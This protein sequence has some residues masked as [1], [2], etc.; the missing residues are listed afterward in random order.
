MAG[1]TAQD[2]EMLKFYSAKGNRELYFNYLAQKEGNDGYGLLALGVVRN[3]NAPGATANIFA[4][5]QARDDGVRMSER[6]WQAFGVELMRNDFALR[7][8]QVDAGRPDLALN[9]PVKDVQ[10]SHDPTFRRREINPDAWTPRQLL[11][12]ARRHGGE[13]EAEKVWSMM[14]DNTALGV[15]R[16][17]QTTDALSRQYNDAEL[18]ASNYFVAM[19]LA[20]KSAGLFPTPNTDPD[21]IEHDGKTYTF[22]AQ[23][24]RWLGPAP[25]ESRIPVPLPVSDP[26]LIESLNDTR[27]LRQERQQLREQFHPDDPNRQRPI[28]ASPWLLSDAAPER[29]E[30]NPSPQVAHSSDPTHPDH[31]RHALHQQCVAGVQALDASMGRQ[32]DE[33]SACMA[34]S[35]TALAASKGLERVDQVVLSGHGTEASPGQYVFVV[36]GDRENPAHQRAHMSTDQAVGTPP[37]QSFQRLA[38]LDQEH[39]QERGLQA[40]REQNV[41]QDVQARSGPAMHA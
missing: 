35:L 7:Q 36:Q 12:A 18:S 22:H 6:D 8:Q 32:W 27:E 10:A 5:S 1:L 14:L 15:K 33:R 24:G 30:E 41:Q 20:R 16:G 40:Q 25:I 9:L 28:M 21:R 4:D 29:G 2:M 11:E 17:A 19:G 13:A 37:E 3:D 34:A 23:S 39:A 38:A 26:A 31:P